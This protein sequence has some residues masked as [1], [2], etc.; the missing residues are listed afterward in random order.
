MANKK[1][2][3]GMLV[4]VL[5]F[6]MTVVGCSNDNDDGTTLTTSQ[7]AFR[8][9]ALADWNAMSAADRA[10]ANEWL[11]EIGFPQN[12]PSWSNADWVRFYNFMDGEW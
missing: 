11:R 5:V 2:W 6:G 4:L 1:F 3:V 12:P 10:E 7:S 8:A 9:E